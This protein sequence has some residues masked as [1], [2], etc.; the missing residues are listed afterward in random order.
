M[1]IKFFFNDTL[2]SLSN[3]VKLKQQLSDIFS[4]EG[5]SLSSLSYIFCTD[6]YLHAINLEFLGHDDYTDIITFSLAE[7]G[8][9]IVGEIYISTD[10]IRENAVKNKVTINNE[11][12]RVLFHGALHLCGYK[13][14]TKNDK[15]I[16]TSKED[17]Y[18]S[19]YFKHHQ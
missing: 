15:A 12:H 2:I 19:Q 16:M 4:D 5:K 13:D 17:Y 11:L 6:K 10:R 14:K 9:S 1:K 3:R 8:A 18:L 7:P